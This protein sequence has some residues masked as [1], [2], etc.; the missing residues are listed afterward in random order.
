MGAD[1]DKLKSSSADEEAPQ[2]ETSHPASEKE[3]DAGDKDAGT[4]VRIQRKRSGSIYETPRWQEQVAQGSEDP[5]SAVVLFSV[6]EKHK[7]SR[8][9]TVA[10]CRFRGKGSPLR[11]IQ[12]ESRNGSET[13]VVITEFL[14]A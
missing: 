11:M 14:H 6:D 12:E 5:A 7:L 13:C 3:S 9:Y 10:A 1:L 8:A 2:S 4:E